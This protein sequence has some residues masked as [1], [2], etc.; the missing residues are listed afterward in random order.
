MLG[1]ELKAKRIQV[2]RKDPPDLPE[3]SAYP[4]EL[5]QV[6]TNL[7]D[8][9]IDAL[10]EGGELAV[11]TAREGEQVVIRVVDNG[12][13]IPEAVRSRIFEPFFTTKAVG[14]GT[15]L[16]LDIVQRI[17]RQHSGQ[18]GVESRPGRTVF[19]VR[20]PVGDG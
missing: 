18:I 17:V 15:G 8:N 1:H 19:T 10:P 12:S 7:I 5:N 6:F 20:L 4:G 9:A 14:E 11:E 16:G 13:G 2:S 3:I